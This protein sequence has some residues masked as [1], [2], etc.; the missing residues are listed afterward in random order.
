M[1]LS[2][3]AT[4]SFY[5]LQIQFY[6]AY[7]LRNSWQAGWLAGWLAGKL[8]VF[9]T[10]EKKDDDDGCMLTAAKNEYESC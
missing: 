8:A 7:C 10:G 9:L 3:I 6:L 2:K 5:I 1:H 4:K